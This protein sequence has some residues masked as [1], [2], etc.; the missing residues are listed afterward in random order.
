MAHAATRGVAPIAPTAWRNRAAMPLAQPLLRWGHLETQHASL[1]AVSRPPPAAQDGEAVALAPPLVG[2]RHFLGTIA[3]RASRIAM[4]GAPVTLANRSAVNLAE[5]V[6]A[7]LGALRNG[8]LFG[9][10]RPQ[11]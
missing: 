2:R 8:F 3:F 4:P 1:G 7:R 5:L 10:H 11:A 6:R 9:F